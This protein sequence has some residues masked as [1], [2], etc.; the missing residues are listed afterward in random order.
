MNNYVTST[1]T[2]ERVRLGSIIVDIREIISISLIFKIGPLLTNPQFGMYDESV[3]NIM[4][5]YHDA[6]TVEFK[7]VLGHRI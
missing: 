4:N 1:P 7:V 2:A 6:A 5:D 3:F